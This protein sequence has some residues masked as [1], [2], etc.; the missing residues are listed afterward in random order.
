[1]PRDRAASERL[2]LRVTPD[3]LAA[4]KA[5]AGRELLDLSAWVRLA[6]AHRAAAGEPQ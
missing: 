4:F 1:M 5:A 2:Q 3:E 6:C